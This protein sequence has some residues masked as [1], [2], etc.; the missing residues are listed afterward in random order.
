M[1]FIILIAIYVNN[2]SIGPEVFSLA[3]FLEY[4]FKEFYPKTCFLA[5]FLTKKIPNF[6]PGLYNVEW[7]N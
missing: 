2:R 3:H 6:F 1:T 5:I 7:Q 4:E